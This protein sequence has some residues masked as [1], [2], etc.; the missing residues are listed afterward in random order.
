MKGRGGAKEG[1]MLELQLHGSIELWSPVPARSTLVGKD[2]LTNH[3]SNTYHALD[4]RRAILDY[5]S[6]S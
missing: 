3:A 6:E 4:S 1:E 5:A 2:S